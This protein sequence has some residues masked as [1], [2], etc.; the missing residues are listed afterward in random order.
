MHLVN[1]KLFG[2]D[3]KV[4]K[5]LKLANNIA[6][7]R[8]P[9]LIVGEIG[10]GK[11]MLSR[12]IHE[13]SHRCR[14]VFK[15]IDCS[16][17]PQLVKDK[18]LGARDEV[19]ERFNKGVLELSHKGSVIFA[20]IDSLEEEFQKKLYKII[21]ELPDYELDIRFMATTTK[22]ISKLVGSGRFYR[23]LYTLFSAE[24]LIVPPLRERVNDLEFLARYFASHTKNKNGN[25][26]IFSQPAMDKILSHY[27]THNIY[28]LQAVLEN[29]VVN[30]ES[31]IL[32]EVDL[33]IGEKK[34]VKMI[35]K[36]DNEGIRL[37]SLKEAEK[38]LIKKAL[39][40]TSENRTQAAKILGVSIRTLRNK[41][42]EYRSRGNIYF[43][44]LR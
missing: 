21:L 38:I 6:I 11:R 23:G 7:T 35:T 30:L 13:R 33:E 17:D 20:N 40:H 12:L 36:D 18:I 22:N 4:L 28:E 32:L 26:I 44:S 34:A 24:T 8:S 10:I 41:I 37:M 2:V 9:V 39:M 27:W 14:E 31:D 16:D 5:I 1:E 19:T 42:N 43:L 29:S 25:E 15:I 3:P